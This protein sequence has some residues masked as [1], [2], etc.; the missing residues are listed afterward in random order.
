MYVY[1][2]VSLVCI[3]Y[4]F[5]RIGYLPHRR[6]RSKTLK[7]FSGVRLSVCLPAYLP[8]CW[9]VGNALSSKSPLAPPF[10]S[11]PLFV[12][13]TLAYTHSLSLSYSRALFA[14]A[15]AVALTL[16]GSRQNK[17]AQQALAIRTRIVTIAANS[18]TPDSAAS[19]LSLRHA[20]RLCSDQNQ[21]S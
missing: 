11:I 4:S 1:M 20:R 18:T 21:R 19:S 8:R 12:V 17:R 13:P 6:R 9:L 16:I 3:Y 10:H 14:A 2:Y 5:V 15:A 7:S